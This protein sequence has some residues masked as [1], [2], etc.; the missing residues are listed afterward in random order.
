MLAQLTEPEPVEYVLPDLGR[1]KVLLVDDRVG[2]LIAL[3]AI[4][5]PLEQTLVTASSGFDALRHLL[6]DEFAVILMDVQMPEMNGFE[7]AN[8]IKSRPK[9]RHIPI[10][11]VTAVSTELKYVYRGYSAGAV[12]Y[13]S[14]PFNPEIL[15]SKVSVF[16][17]LYFKEKELIR[18]AE[19][20][21]QSIRREEEMRRTEFESEVEQVRLRE[22]AERLE[23]L[24]AERTEQLQETNRDLEAFCYSIAHDLRTPIREI[25]GISGLLL[26]DCGDKLGEEDLKNLKRQSVAAKSMGR[27]IDDLLR[28]SR[29]GRQLTALEPVDLS[30]LAR[31]TIENAVSRGKN[32]T[33]SI[34][35]ELAAECDPGLTEILLQNLADNAVKY[36]PKGGE[37]QFG[38]A[39][40]DGSVAFFL[41]DHGIGFDM[42]YE[43]KLF[44]PFERL[45]S[46]SK[47]PGNGIG[48]ALVQKIVSKHGGKV[49]AE[50]AM[51]EGATFY[52]TLH[53][54]DSETVSPT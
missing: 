48:L 6:N 20:L 41:R 2:N 47:Y 26:S 32:F 4:L 39:E 33:V 7:T 49:W 19:M 24:V 34:E 52:F 35:K 43:R 51:G 12:D 46:D 15:R 9:C 13:I 11:F 44:L 36:S 28:L 50:G 3:E 45:V 23:M 5:Q 17:D 38:V 37:I 14:K 18:Q 42:R 10:I 21:N 22:S 25:V 29:L 30:E 54:E 8:F 27:L 16:V 40:V 1:A 31:Q 53:R